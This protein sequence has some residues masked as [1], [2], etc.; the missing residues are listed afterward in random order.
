MVLPNSR[1]SFNPRKRKNRRILV[2]S[3]TAVILAVIAFIIFTVPINRKEKIAA[4]NIKS[5]SE[6]IVELW[7]RKRYDEIIQICETELQQKPLNQQALMFCGFSYF[8]KGSAQFNLE[9][10]I[11]LLDKAVIN[12]RKALALD[13]E[14]LKGRISYIL[15]KTYFHKGKYYYDLSIEY[16][17]SSI[18]S[19]YL[20][21]DT[22]EYL[23]LAYLNLE[24][25]KK[26]VEYFLLAAEN[27]ASDTLYLVLGQSYYKLNDLNKAEEYLIWTL[28]RTKDIILEQKSR[29]LLGQIYKET[30]KL[31]KAEEQYKRVLELN[32]HSADAYYFLGEIYEELQDRA[33]SRFHWRKAL[34]ID[35]YHYG[36]RLKLY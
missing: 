29:M 11:P 3:I 13:N 30:K 9:D 15:S 34:E 25:Y 32:P 20:A 19:G 1:Y 24:N 12:L 17:H 22:Y 26:S 4:R 21:E 8:Y 35:P 23:G 18:Q 33:K 36:A 6:S 28:N 5:E 7:E 31:L 10:K 2:L 27:N 16:M 14:V